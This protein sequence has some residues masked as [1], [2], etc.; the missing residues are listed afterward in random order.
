VF[1]GDFLIDCEM[2]PVASFVFGVTFT[3]H[4]RSVL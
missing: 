4:M 2:V 3:F 1:L